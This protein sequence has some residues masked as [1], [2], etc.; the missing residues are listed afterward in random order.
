LAESLSLLFGD[1]LRSILSRCQP[2]RAADESAIER[3]RNLA[4]PW[5]TENPGGV[6]VPASRVPAPPS[7][8]F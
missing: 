1:V 8:A 2:S 4:D 7:D 5:P 6:Q 3:Y